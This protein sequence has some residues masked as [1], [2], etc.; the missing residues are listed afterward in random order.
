MRRDIDRYIKERVEHLEEY[1]EKMKARVTEIL[2]YK[3]VGTF[4]WVGIACKELE[5]IPSKDAISVLEAMPSDLH[6]LYERLFSAALKKE[7]EKDTMRLIMGFVA[8]SR[9]PLNLGQQILS[10]FQLARRCVI[11]TEEEPTNV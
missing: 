4:L 2:K 3:A 6:A 1:T 8:V 10:Y 11:F 5:D 9:R 7:R